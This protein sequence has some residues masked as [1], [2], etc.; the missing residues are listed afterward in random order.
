MLLFGGSPPEPGDNPKHS[1]GFTIL[2]ETVGTFLDAP[3]SRDKT[4]N[5]EAFA[6]SCWAFVHGMAS[7]SAR[8]A[9]MTNQ[10]LDVVHRHALTR[11][12]CGSDTEMS[13]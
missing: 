11:F 5:Q 4:L 8:V 10:N 7:L 6:Y 13:I 1:S 2:L 12:V 9:G 3:A